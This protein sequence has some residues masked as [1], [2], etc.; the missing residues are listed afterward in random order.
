[1]GMRKLFN[2][3]FIFLVLLLPMVATIR[4]S[5]SKYQPPGA[6]ILK[7]SR[8][9]LIMEDFHAEADDYNG[10]GGDN[11][12]YRRYGDVPSPGVGH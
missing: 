11:D 4:H 6:T 1:M 9:R 8:K 10:N 12:Y 2:V 5:H 3:L 7:A